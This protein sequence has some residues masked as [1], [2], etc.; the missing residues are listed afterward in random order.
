MYRNGELI[1]R[2]KPQHRGDRLLHRALGGVGNA[3]GDDGIVERLDPLEHV[4]DDREA[5][6][7]RGLA[8]GDEVVGDAAAEAADGGVGGR[9]APP[10]RR[11]VGGGGEEAAREGREEGR[12]RRLLLRREIGDAAEHE[13]AGGGCHA[14]WGFGDVERGSESSCRLP[15]W[16][17]DC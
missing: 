6:V 12:R 9:G 17:G 4:G 2:Q 15:L 5:P 3:L 8:R 16:F 10:G 13:G 1:R 11:G 7:E 14:R